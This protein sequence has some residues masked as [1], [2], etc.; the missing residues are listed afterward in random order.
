MQTN[1]YENKDAGR[2]YYDNYKTKLARKSL[3]I[4]FAKAWYAAT[5]TNM[6]SEETIEA[7]V[8][9]SGTDEAIEK[10][11]TTLANTWYPKK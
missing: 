1:T 6:P 10:A 2:E 9:L 7:I 11:A 3:K 8:V 5:D 4:T